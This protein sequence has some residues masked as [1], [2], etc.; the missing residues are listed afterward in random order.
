MLN[1][2]RFNHC[3]GLTFFHFIAH[4]DPKRHHLTWHGRFEA[5]AILGLDAH[6]RHAIHQG[7]DITGMI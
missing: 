1:F 3:Q 7:D 4:I 2:H 6:M 5:T